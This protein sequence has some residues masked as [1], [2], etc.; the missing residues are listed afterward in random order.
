MSKGASSNLTGGQIQQVL[1]YYIYEALKPIVLCSNVFDV[2]I[3]HI[4]SIVA[5]NRKR[6]LSALEREEFISK[7]CGVL[8]QKDRVE[9]HKLLSLCK[10]ERGFVYNFIVSLLEQTKGYEEI[11]MNYLICRDVNERQRLNQRLAAIEQMVGFGR[12]SLYPALSTIKANLNLMYTFRN[13]IVKQYIKHSFKKAVEYR[14]MKAGTDISLRDLH[15]NL[16]T[17]IVKSIDKYDCSKGALTS[18]VNFWILNAM[19]Y[20]N[21]MHGHE[22]G[23]AYTIPQM[24]KKNIV[25]GKG[26]GE[27]N[28]GVSLDQVVTEGDDGELIDLIEGSESVEDVLVR[29]AEES[30]LLYLIKLADRNGIFRLWNDIDE[31]MSANEKNRMLRSMIKGGL[32]PSNVTV[33]QLE[34]V[35]Q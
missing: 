28:I 20:A 6:K 35:K 18:Y 34:S 2:Q 31:Y 30:N 26:S 9:K 7:L 13:S 29:N 12:G 1:D 5:K 16:L 27:V 17:A 21:P 25:N 11:Y 32:V 4:L 3:I 8:V 33:K 23:V 15:Q 24:Q 10:I 22:Y 14:K 19:T